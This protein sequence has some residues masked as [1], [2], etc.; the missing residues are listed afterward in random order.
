MTEAAVAATGGSVI[1]L[2]K[3]LGETLRRRQDWVRRVQWIFVAIYLVLLLAPVVWP[4][5]G[6]D[7][8]RRLALVVELIFWGVWWPGVLL[9]TLLF[10]QVWCGLLCPD[11]TV[12]EF[13]SRRGRGG[14]IPAALRWSGWPVLLVIFLWAG[15]HA[16]DAHR[17]PVA[18]LGF[19]GLASL[20]AWVTGYLLYRGKR[21]WCRYLC[22]VA[23]VF[24]LLARCAFLHF[25]VDRDAWDSTR[26]LP[27][28]AVDCPLLLDVR[29]L[30]GNEKCSMCGRCS[31]HRQAVALSLRPPGSEIAAMTEKDARYRDTFAI[32]FVL[33]GLG[34]AVSHGVP[35]G[36]LPRSAA[37]FLAAGVIGALIAI[38]LL[39]AAGGRP[40]Q[41]ALLSHGLI[42]LA[43]CGLLAG[44]LDQTADILD[45]LQWSVQVPSGLSRLVVGTGIVGS[46]A[47]GRKLIG[48]IVAGTARRAAAF[49]LFGTTVA[50]L[51][52]LYFG[53]LC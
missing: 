37:V 38:Q 29:R 44:A 22:P 18:T 49:L 14:K 51:V 48:T 11:G 8:G 32:C 7:G 35:L 21:V 20:A 6:A 3:R 46:M 33:I 43:G 13:L 42:P 34:Y 47:V 41:A 26:P 25:R 39:A 36:G 30:R 50:L 40:R 19:L 28:Q 4:A 2:P 15:E 53:C 45:R 16:L 23:G 17:S 27:G 31:G 9:A 52:V 5:I 12:S 24:S 1:P 10:G